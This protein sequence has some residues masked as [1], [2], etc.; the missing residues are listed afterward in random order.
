MRFGDLVNR[1]KDVVDKRG[2]TD[3]LKRDA[4]QLKDIAR[5]PGSAQ[6]KAKRA[7][8]ALKKPRGAT[9]RPPHRPEDPGPREP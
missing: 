6:D 5:G 9:E 7:A 3:Q 1:A 8:D 4:E 2:G